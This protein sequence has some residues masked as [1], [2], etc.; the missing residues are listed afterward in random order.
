MD[1]DA[2]ADQMA[3]R[4]KKGPKQKSL[5]HLDEAQMKDMQKYCKNIIRLSSNNIKILSKESS[6]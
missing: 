3:V 1:H 2:I 5:V 6:E 4:S